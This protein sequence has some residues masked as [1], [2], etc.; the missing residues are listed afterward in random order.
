MHF[1]NSAGKISPPPAASIPISAVGHVLVC[2][3]HKFH[4]YIV[5]MDLPAVLVVYDGAP[6]S[7][8][9]APGIQ[10]AVIIYRPYVD[11]RDGTVHVVAHRVL[12]PGEKSDILDKL[13]Q[14]QR[15]R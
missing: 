13:S 5:K 14:K 11:M 3:V 2:P 6:G 12:E 8:V 4:L 10:R 7:P 15:C 1:K 9:A